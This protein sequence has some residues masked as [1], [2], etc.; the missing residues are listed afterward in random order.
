MPT[1]D[2]PAMEDKH[3]DLMG[4]PVELREEIY[5]LAFSAPYI[6]DHDLLNKPGPPLDLRL[7]STFVHAE[8]M[9]AYI[10]AQ[11]GFEDTR[12]DFIESLQDTRRARHSHNDRN[13]LDAASDPGRLAFLATVMAIRWPLCEHVCAER[14]CYMCSSPFHRACFGCGMWRALAFYYS[15][16]PDKTPLLVELV[17]T[18]VV[19]TALGFKVRE[20]TALYK[21]DREDLYRPAS[22]SNEHLPSP[23]RSRYWWA[24]ELDKQLHV[25][26]RCKIRRRAV[27]RYW[28]VQP[29]QRES[30]DEETIAELEDEDMDSLSMHRWTSYMEGSGWAREFDWQSAYARFVAEEQ[31][32]LELAGSDKKLVP[33]E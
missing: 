5:G 4:L 13:S 29:F 3:S 11:A 32:Q 2:S 17:G 24:V 7:T 14:G 1:I 15:S 22:R 20:G 10:K 33:S 28:A 25:A 19:H 9:R 26:I 27:D 16:R 8:T 30:F 21:M 18:S 31:R 23:A 12:K 6:S